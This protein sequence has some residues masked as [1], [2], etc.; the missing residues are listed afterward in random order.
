MEG[1]DSDKRSLWSKIVEKVCEKLTY[2]FGHDVLFLCLVWLMLAFP[3]CMVQIAKGYYFNLFLY[4]LLYLVVAYILL[5]PLDLARLTR[6]TLKPCFF[7][8]LTVFTAFD[9][10]SIYVYHTRLTYDIFEIVAATNAEEVKEYLSMYVGWKEFVL[11][12]LFIAFATGA[13]IFSQLSPLRQRLRVRGRLAGVLLGA[14]ALTAIIAFPSLK[15][16]FVTWDFNFEMVAD[17]SKYPTHPQLEAVD[18][19]HPTNVVVIIGESFT[20]SHSS[21]YGYD[22]PTNPS[23]DSL[24]HDGNLVVFSDARS[25]APH[26]T[27]AFKY[28]LNTLRKDDKTTKWYKSTHLI[29]ALNTAG[30]HTVWLS[31]QAETG[32]YNNLSSAASKICDEKQF[33]RVYNDDV[34]FDEQLIEFDTPSPGQQRAVVYHLMGQHYMFRNRYP[35]NF[36]VFKTSEY[37]SASGGDAEKAENLATY[38]NATLY[39]DYVVGRIMKKYADTDAIIFYFSDHGLDVY[40][41]DPDYCGHALDTS[42]SLDVGLKIPFM[43][44]MTPAYRERH[45]ELVRGIVEMK[46]RPIQTDTVF[47]TILRSAGY[48]LKR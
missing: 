38:D 11:L 26:T 5:V 4:L 43:V 30:Y 31:N 47:H 20:P 14:S 28:I 44:Y 9:L 16:Q 7:A 19:I 46:N 24:V 33:L 37:G 1:F 36:D 29:E 13:Y 2:P 15:E 8:I 40:Q 3:E 12:G 17:L 39:N 48:S 27:E 6:L 41:S 32:L 22:K 34:V 25:P 10:F 23:L 18:S 42:R 35:D 21:L 45:P